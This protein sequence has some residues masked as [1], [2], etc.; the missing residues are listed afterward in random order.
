MAAATDWP[1]A[2][3]STIGQW[4]AAQRAAIDCALCAGTTHTTASATAITAAAALA[5]HSGTPSTR[6]REG[7]PAG[8]ARETADRC[9]RRPAISITAG[10]CRSSSWID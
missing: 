6:D 1:D 3:R 10:V 9:D 4:T 2:V 5:A 7:A 8:V